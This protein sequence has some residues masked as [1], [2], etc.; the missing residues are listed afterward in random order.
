MSGNV[1]MSLGSHVFAV[2]PVGYQRLEVDLQTKWTPMKNVGVY[3]KYQW[4][5]PGSKMTRIE[6]VVYPVE[7]GGQAQLQAMLQSTEA[8]EVMMLTSASGTVFGPHA[9][10]TIK[11]KD[12]F[13]SSQGI[14]R[15]EEYMMELIYMDDGLSLSGIFGRGFL[16]G[17]L[18]IF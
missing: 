15:K 11:L 16:G 3:D 17:A 9:I 5:G 12:S 4:L 14:P 6:G 18:S 2:L 8:G 7:Y 1:L 13:V 10:N